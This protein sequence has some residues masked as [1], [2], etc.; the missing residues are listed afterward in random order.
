MG[1]VSED[2]GETRKVQR[3]VLGAK[4][5]SPEDKREMLHKLDVIMI[6]TTRTAY[7]MSPLEY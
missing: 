5:I 6:N 2:L 4:D 3:Y 7:G 1:K